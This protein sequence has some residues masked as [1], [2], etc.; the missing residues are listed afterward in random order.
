M[1]E[2]ST[3]TIQTSHFGKNSTP[4]LIKNSHCSSKDFKMMSLGSKAESKG[5]SIATCSI[6]VIFNLHAT[7][8]ISRTYVCKDNEVDLLWL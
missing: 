7:G 1:N 5:V 4:G 3:L 8:H 6:S 2:T